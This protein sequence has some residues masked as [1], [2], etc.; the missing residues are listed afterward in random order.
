MSMEERILLEQKLLGRR[1]AS[2]KDSLTAIQPRKTQSE[3]CELSFAQNRL[4]LVEHLN[5]MPGN[6]NISRVYRIR[7]ALNPAA[8]QAAL[9]ALVGRHEALRTRLVM[10]G[11]MP[12]QVIEPRQPVTMKTLDLQQ[13]GED[14]CKSELDDFVRGIT[15]SVFDLSA[16]CMLRAGLAQLGHGEFL[17]AITMHHIAS[18]GWSL[19]V[20]DRELEAFYT[21]YDSGAAATLP[22]L[23]VQY[24]DYAVWQRSWL[25]GAVLE[26][27]LGYWREQLA[28][29]APLELPTDH[30][31]PARLSYRGDVERLELQAELVA[32]LKALARQHNATLYMVLLAAFQVLLMRYSGQEDIAVGSPV[33]GRNRPE[34]EGLIGFFVNTLV[35]RGDLSGNPRFSELL[36]Q[37]RNYALDAYAH[38]D[39]PFEKLVEELKPERDM[40]RNP[41]F[42]VM[43]ALQNTPEG[44]LH[45]A[46]LHS[47]RLPLHNGTAKFDL[48]LSLTE[49]TEGLH[50]V[51]EYATDLFDAATIARLAGHFTT[52]LEEIVA[53]P[54]QRIGLLPLLTEAERHQLLV[55]WNN[56]ATDYP[57][58]RCVHQLFEAQAART[59]DAIAVVFGEQQLTYGE[60][61]ARANRLAHHLRSLGIGADS[62]VGLCIERSLDMV[63]GTLAILKAGGA[64]VPLDPDYPQDRLDFMLHDTGAKVVLTQSG[65]KDRLPGVAVKRLCLDSDS[66]LW[67]EQPDSNPV[68]VATPDS[69]A[70]VIYTSGST[71]QPKGVMVCHRS[72]ARLVC[73]TSYA[74]FDENQTFLLLAPIAFDASTFELW[75]AL[76]HGARC[77]IYPD[78]VPTPL[79]LEQALQRHKVDTLW[80]TASL[81][82]FLIDE[83][84]EI[85][86]GVS[87]LLTGGEALSLPHV[88]RAL[89][90]LP[91]TQLINGYGP[92]ESTT[93]ACCYPIPRDLTEDGGSV[94]I[95]R[96]ISNTV[97][98]VL[99]G[100]GNLAPI[101]VAGE[102]YI[103]GAGL[104]RGYLNRPELTAEH[105]VASPL[106]PGER[107]YRTGDRVRW[108]EDGVIEF[109]GRI[110]QQIKLRGYRI[111]PGE[112]EAVLQEDDAIRQS[113]VM[114]REDHPGDKRLVAY[115]VGQGIDVEALRVRL[116][117]RLPDYMIPGAFVVLDS[118]P[119]TPNGKVD[120]KALPVPE[121]DAGASGYQAPRT[122]LE[123]TIAG[124]WA[125]TLKLPRV[126]I[127]DNFFDLGGHSLLAAQLVNRINRALEV[128]LVLRQLFDTPTVNGLACAALD[129]L[130][131]GEADE[132]MTF[133]GEDE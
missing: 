87:Q 117:G 21:A 72:I 73:G 110:D 85:L 62:L 99:D 25:S 53:D 133:P 120:R 32:S 126:G 105:F 94:P 36:A 55:E 81:F 115:L 40:S 46:G 66:A 118:L 39:L 114:V 12:R 93:F 44:D 107:L 77:A 113:L 129:R 16:D 43:F 63:V 98:H 125:E 83:K 116:K 104:A 88:Q 92:T 71:G 23:P 41:L 27:Q 132:D 37:T 95:G 60:L 13:C 7:G 8:I 67:S 69:L 68:P 106:Q 10:A 111:E 65:L 35:M 2:A 52:L 48:T 96:P 14:N 57:R 59:P 97:C 84:P 4:W 6:Y 31:R 42:Q 119:L 1:K 29:L 101:G 64:Y 19:S 50:G 26:R 70:Y 45:L 127:H 18:D 51:L 15:R 24:A 30:A 122:P 130:V 58:D 38:Q 89:A 47:E 33:A 17:L 54:E 9:D 79:S 78:R 20:L 28:G 86:A 34:L 108:R 102:L 103:G 90:H 75:G 123:T 128:D 49:Q 80:L 11:G 82:N 91:K 56:T 124:I 61:D 112:I 22:P 100:H 74:R 5:P 121:L 131:M 3:H 109:L 76:L